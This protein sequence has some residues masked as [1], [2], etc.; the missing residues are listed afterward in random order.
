[1]EKEEDALE[2]TTRRDKKRRITQEKV[3]GE[4]PHQD[5]TDKKSAVNGAVKSI[6]IS[7]TKKGKGQ[8]LRKKIGRDLGRPAQGLSRHH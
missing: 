6:A 8:L 3:K 2:S 1:M 5:L 7:E 4:I